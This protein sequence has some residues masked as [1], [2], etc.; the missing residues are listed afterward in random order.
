MTKCLGG[1]IVIRLVPKL[2]FGYLWL[3]TLVAIHRI[4]PS[5]KEMVKLAPS[6]FKPQKNGEKREI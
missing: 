6:S 1:D 4:E 2:D 3:A 5:A